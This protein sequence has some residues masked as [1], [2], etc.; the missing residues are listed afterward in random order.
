MSDKPYF[1]VKLKV[2]VQKDMDIE[3]FYQADTIG[4]AM[5]AAVERFGLEHNWDDAK[6]V[7]A[8]AEPHPPR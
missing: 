3:E 5:D 8:T 2:R 1:K 6:V 7:T 4:E